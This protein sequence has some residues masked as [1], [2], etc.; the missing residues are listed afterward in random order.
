MSD[1]HFTGFTP[2]ALTFLAQLRFYNAPDWF[3]PR[4]TI[5]E[6]VLVAPIVALLGEVR[7]AANKA[8]IP[9]AFDPKAG[10][11]RVQR[12]VRFAKDKQP[13]K[14]HAAGVLSRNGRKDDPGMLYFH[15]EPGRSFVAVGFWHP[16]PELI[17]AWRTD[18]IEHPER[19]L[20]V[21]RALEKSGVTLSR[22]EAYK[23][24]P[25]DFDAAK[26]TATEE[27]VKQR[28]LIC[29]TPLDDAVILGPG[30]GVADAVAGFLAKTTPLL[31]YGWQL[32]ER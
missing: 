3:K 26:G 24:L 9:F 31:N 1:T 13:Y 16:P 7:D 18:M 27:H 19:F 8:G 28:H 32:M 21:A 2:E 6:T 25:R 15:I 14:T 4:K 17:Q 5:Y 22:E 12:D 23:R 20:K 30:Q 11:F 10:M 29:E